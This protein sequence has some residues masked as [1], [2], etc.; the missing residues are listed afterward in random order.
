MFPMLSLLMLIDGNTYETI[1]NSTALRHA[2]LLIA[3]Y[4]VGYL[5]GPEIAISLWSI[6]CSST[7]IVHIL[8]V[9]CYKKHKKK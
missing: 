8:I 3:E 7:L 5:Y 9:Q 6:G 1:P 2:V 4:F